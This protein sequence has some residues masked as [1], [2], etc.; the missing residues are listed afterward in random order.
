M[1]LR[2]APS[3]SALITLPSSNS[4]LLIDTPS[5][6]RWPA[7][8]DRG[9]GVA[10]AA[11]GQNWCVESKV[12]LCEALFCE[13]RGPIPH[14]RTQAHV[15]HTTHL[16]SPS[17]WPVHCPPGPRGA[18]PDMLCLFLVHYHPLSSDSHP[19]TRGPTPHTPVVPVSLARSLPARSTR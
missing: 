12:C 3:V 16:W 18:S 15:A 10:T 9:E 13:S 4:P 1:C 17:P 7:V 19:H 2:E 8:D 11:E 6:K 5:A 14:H